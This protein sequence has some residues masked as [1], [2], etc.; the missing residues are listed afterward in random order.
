MRKILPMAVFVVAVLIGQL[1]ANAQ[2]NAPSVPSRLP[3][4]RQIQPPAHAPTFNGYSQ[5]RAIAD[6]GAPGSAGHGYQHFVMPMDK[7]TSWYRPRAATLTPAQRCA[8]PRFRPRG[9]GDLFA[10]SCDGF[11]M[12]YSPFTLSNGDASYGPSYIARQP[13]PRCED[14]DHSVGH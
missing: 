11:R 7:Y 4:A 13:D 3:I 1:S 5:Y 8:P 2:Q 10:E 14:C 9:F 6:Q 12:E